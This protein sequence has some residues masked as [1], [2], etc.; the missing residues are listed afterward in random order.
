MN[1]QEEIEANQSGDSL[2]AG[3]PQGQAAGESLDEKVACALCGIKDSK[4]RMIPY[5]A[6]DMRF[7]ANVNP[8]GEWLCPV[9]G[10]SPESGRGVV[11]VKPYTR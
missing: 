1:G 4:S 10:W 2:T 11:E 9:C 5:L 3:L 8:V 7:P 6:S